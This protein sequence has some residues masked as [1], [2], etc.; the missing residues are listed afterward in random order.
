V[1]RL[2]DLRHVSKFDQLDTAFRVL[3]KKL[4]VEV[5]DAA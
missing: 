5:K 1:D 2:L 4:V 3:G